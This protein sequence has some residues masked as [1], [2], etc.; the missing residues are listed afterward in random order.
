MQKKIGLGLG[1]ILTLIFIFSI[2]F[3]VMRTP[4][5]VHA[6]KTAAQ[7][8]HE[9]EEKKKQIAENK[10]RQEALIQLILENNHQKALL[11]KYQ[12]K[13]SVEYKQLQEQT[14]YIQ[15]QQRLLQADIDAAQKD[16][17]DKTAQ[18]QER[19]RVMYE[20]SSFSYMQTIFE[21]KGLLDFLDRT[22]LVKRVVA[23]D[24][25]LMEEVRVA[26]L[27][28]SY[29]LQ[30]KE[31]REAELAKAAAEK[32]QYINKLAASQQAIAGKILDQQ[33]LIKEYERKENELEAET[34]KIDADIK[35]LAETG[36]TFHGGKFDWPVPGGSHVIDAG[37]AFG[38]RMHPIYHV[39]RMHSGVDIR[40]SMGQTIVAVGDGK[41]LSASYRSGYGNTVIIDHGG[42]ITTL[43]AHCSV[44]LVSAGEEV[45][46]GETIA[47]AG[48]TGWSTGAHLHFEVRKNGTPVDPMKG[49]IG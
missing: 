24:Q 11:N 25:M 35:K 15:E 34:K 17:K 22:E 23:H 41:V 46:R 43:Y 5:T 2:A 45:K 31:Q 37:S 16:L 36:G 20:N 19:I 9:K 47:K 7:L 13:T 42:G 3:G 6:T 30:A 40:A 49:W 4:T 44:L 21:S 12:D 28:L 26:K 38:M 27:D 48:S 8:K 14:D 29:K 33:N 18:L 1:V 10:R 32:L 39:W